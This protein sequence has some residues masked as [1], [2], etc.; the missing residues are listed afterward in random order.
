MGEVS[1]SGHGMMHSY[2]GSLFG[3]RGI[4][5]DTQELYKFKIKKKHRQLYAR[6]VSPTFIF[7]YAWRT[8][9]YDRNYYIY[10]IFA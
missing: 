4:A 7:K 10:V 2:S 9:D 5:H 3:E 8:L 6:R 1:K